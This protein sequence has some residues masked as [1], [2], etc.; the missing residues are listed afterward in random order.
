MQG[1]VPAH[2]PLQAVRFEPAPGFGVSVM[3]VPWRK[4]AVQVV[5]QSM[6]AGVVV[7]APLPVT[8]TFSV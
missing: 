1:L 6:P 4:V 3:A 5:P 8:V 7:T 2:A